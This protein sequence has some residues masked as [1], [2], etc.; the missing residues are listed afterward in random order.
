MG[1]RGDDVRG[2]KE[3]RREWDKKEG[4]GCGKGRQE[5]RGRERA[6]EEGMEC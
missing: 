5:G 3:G 1:V 2:D 6:K 4:I